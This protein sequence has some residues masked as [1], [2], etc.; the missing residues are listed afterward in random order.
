MMSELLVCHRNPLNYSLTIQQNQSHL[1]EDDNGNNYYYFNSCYYSL[2]NIFLKIQ[3]L[4]KIEKK[5]DFIE[6]FISDEHL[7]LFPEF[8]QKIT[9]LTNIG[10]LQYEKSIAF[11]DASATAAGKEGSSTATVPVPSLYICFFFFFF[12]SND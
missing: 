4:N 8:Q 9:I 12:E 7:L 1:T 11:K 5:I 10:Y 6:Y 2:R 3:Y